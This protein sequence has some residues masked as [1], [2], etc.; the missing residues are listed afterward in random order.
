M[1]CSLWLQMMKTSPASIVAKSTCLQYWCMLAGVT[2]HLERRSTTPGPIHNFGY[3]QI[4]S[5]CSLCHVVL[6]CA[7]SLLHVNMILCNVIR[8]VNKVHIVAIFNIT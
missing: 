7:S 8:D 5:R 4:D 6:F 2:A 3:S 1:K